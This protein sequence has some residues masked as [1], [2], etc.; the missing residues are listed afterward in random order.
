MYWV[1]SLKLDVALN[2]KEFKSN[3]IVYGLKIMDTCHEHTSPWG[4]TL[5]VKPHHS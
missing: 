1:L 4:G 3:S 2:F 5:M